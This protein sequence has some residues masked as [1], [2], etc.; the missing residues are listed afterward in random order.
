MTTMT[1]INP[2]LE[3]RLKPPEN[4]AAGYTATYRSML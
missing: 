1:P 3:D 4:M 2:N